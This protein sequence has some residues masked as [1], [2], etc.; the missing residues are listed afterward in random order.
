[1]KEFNY[2]IFQAKVKEAPFVFMS[3]KYANKHFHWSFKP[4]KS[5][6]NGTE[7]AKDNYDLLDYLFEKFNVDHPKDFEGHSMSV[8][9]IVKICDINEIRYYYCDSFGWVDITKEVIK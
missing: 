4:Y 7:K 9:D 5:V 1:M 8:S 3:W 6:W 2:E